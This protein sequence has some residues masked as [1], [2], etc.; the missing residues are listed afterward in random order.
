MFNNHDSQDSWKARNM[1]FD[2][3]ISF[4]FLFGIE[5]E[6]KEQRNWEYK[7]AS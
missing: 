6:Q 2:I 1:L 5:E 4:F 3:N 7:S